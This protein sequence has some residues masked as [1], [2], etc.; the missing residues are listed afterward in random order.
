MVLRSPLHPQHRRPAGFRL[1]RLIPALLIAPLVLA[2]CQNRPNADRQRINQLELK[3][4]Q[5]EQRLNQPDLRPDP[6]DKA[7]NPPAGVVKSLT[8]RTESEDDRLRIYWADGSK[9][10]LPC[11]K[12][13]TTLV[14]G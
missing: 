13:Q 14:C 3:V 4:Q 7:G 1:G 10:D 2:G 5:L 11:T 6:A 8:L 9:T 12:E